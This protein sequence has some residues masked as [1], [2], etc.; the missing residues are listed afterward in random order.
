LH[1]KASFALFD[2][3]ETILSALVFSTFFPL[4]ITKHI[5]A[6]TYS[7]LY[8]FSFLGSFFVALLLG[9]IADRR[10]LRKPFFVFFSLLTALMSGV[11]G[12]S[13]GIP[14]L[15]LAVFLILAVSH[16]Q[17]FVFYN[18]LLLNFRAR[19][20]TSGYGVALGYVGSAISLLLLAKYLK[21]PEVYYAVA[22]LFLLLSSPAML[23]L[24]NPASGGD[25]RLSEVL[26]D[27]KFIFFIVC[28]LSMTEVA[29]TL[30]A[31]IGVYLREVYSLRDEQI[32]RVI[33]LSALGGV[34][35]GVFW[36][37]MAELTGVRRVFPAGFAMW[38]VLLFALPFVPE[39]FILLLGLCFG[40]ALSH[41]WTTGRV[42]LLE[43][44]GQETASMRL[45]FLSLT[46][47][48][49]STTGLTLWAFLLHMTDGNFRLSAGFMGIFPLL[50]GVLYFT[51]VFPLRRLS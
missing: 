20:E 26:K 24:P 23:T 18:T 17:A 43:Q 37:K 42:F 34:A 48:I 19:G 3:G 21:D 49:A 4:Y 7:L 47:R 32:Y 28:V 40:F 35:G 50:G 22:V 16:Q 2:S 36:G 5:S 27:R 31:M 12:A 1:R 38:S 46:E 15:A 29:N 44:F 45:S 39:S 14:Y 51:K 33:G 11:L 8:G 13:Y 9:W 6:E 30:I 25:I 10:G 41:L